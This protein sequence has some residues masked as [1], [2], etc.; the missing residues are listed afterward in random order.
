MQELG[1]SDRPSAIIQARVDKLERYET[2]RNSMARLPRIIRRKMHVEEDMEGAAGRDI[3]YITNFDTWASHE[4]ARCA[5]GV[6]ARVR[7]V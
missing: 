5:I 6:L 1:D 2:K 3:S 4:S 7:I